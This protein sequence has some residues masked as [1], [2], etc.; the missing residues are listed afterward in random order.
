MNTV[1]NVNSDPRIQKV[2]VTR[3][4]IIAAPTL[5]KELPFPVKRLIGDLSN[6]DKVLVGLNLAEEIAE[7]KKTAQ[8]LWASL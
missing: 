8:T 5:I 6:R 3:D 2:R 4:Q 1:A 7:G